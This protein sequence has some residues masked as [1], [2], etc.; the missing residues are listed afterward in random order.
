ME[1]V[2]QMLA[3]A[4]NPCYCFSIHLIGLEVFFGPRERMRESRETKPWLSE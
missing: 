4:R 2:M 1:K 3:L